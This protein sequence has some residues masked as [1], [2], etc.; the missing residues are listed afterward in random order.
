MVAV[1]WLEANGF[2]CVVLVERLEREK[3]GAVFLLEGL[4]EGDRSC[5][6]TGW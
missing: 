3:M 2:R 1:S 6:L 4:K 5:V